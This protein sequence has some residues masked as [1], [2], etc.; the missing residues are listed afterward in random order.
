MRA[1][2]PHDGDLLDIHMGQIN[3]KNKFDKI[4]VNT[5]NHKL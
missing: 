5:P 3:Q 4:S 1:A 2:W